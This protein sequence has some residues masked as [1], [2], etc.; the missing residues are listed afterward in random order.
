MPLKTL[1][2][3]KRESHR[4]LAAWK[5]LEN[6][7]DLLQKERQDELWELFT[8]VH[9][10][11]NDETMDYLKFHVKRITKGTVGN[12]SWVLHSYTQFMNIYFL[13]HL[14]SG[15]D[16]AVPGYVHQVGVFNLMLPVVQQIKRTQNPTEMLKKPLPMNVFMK[17]MMDEFSV[18]MN[19]IIKSLKSAGIMDQRSKF[20]EI[21]AW[22]TR[23]K[24]KANTKET[25][26]NFA[27]WCANCNLRL[28]GMKLS[29]C[30]KCLG[31]YY[32]S[33]KCQVEDWHTHHKSNCNK[34]EEEICRNK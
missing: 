12:E 28:K 21:E 8:N 24:T 1:E 7:D 27:K 4:A 14:Y 11:I 2:D 30:S 23:W 31:I 9:N 3:W 25:E 18:T 6:E 32:C 26:V 19:Q 17:A 15:N 20:Y 29:K 10:K 34:T 33:S 13:I 16:R 5:S 22:L